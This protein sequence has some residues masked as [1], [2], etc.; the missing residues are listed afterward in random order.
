M[1][2]SVE[3][4]RSDNTS[5][6][7]GFAVLSSTGAPNG[8]VLFETSSIARLPLTVLLLLDDIHDGP[9]AHC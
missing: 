8:H 6:C 5:D 4:C 7:K 9:F 1:A 2:Q 3:V